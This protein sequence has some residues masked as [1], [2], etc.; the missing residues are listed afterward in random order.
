MCSGTSFATLLFSENFNS[1]ADG[2]L[3]TD[4]SPGPGWTATSGTGTN[5]VT[6]NSG[7]VSLTTSGQDV[8]K[9]FTTASGISAGGSGH[10]YAGFDLT[11]S[12]A[13]TNG[14]YFFSFVS[15]ST[16]NGR[17]YAKSTAGG[18]LLGLQANSAGVIVYGTTVLT[19]NTSNHIVV[20][21]S[22]VTG[23][24]NDTVSVFIAPST[25]SATA[26]ATAIWGGSSAEVGLTSSL[27]R[28]GS[29]ANAP[30]VGKFDNLI[31]ST[32]FSEAAG[33]SA[34]PEPSSVA[35]IAGG[36]AMGAVVMRRRKASSA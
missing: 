28:Q 20:D 7:A 30:T 12:A 2:A 23:T 10:V 3:L 22:N 5:N 9:A 4:V 33:I 8:S 29:S 27:L 16:F 36:L 6:V 13:Q 32:D 14:D 21:Y 19:F 34:V 26:E 31:V 24:L 1:Y 17:L 18:Y 15:G 25:V 11:L 35:L